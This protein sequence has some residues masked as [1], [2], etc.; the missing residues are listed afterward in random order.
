ME[1]LVNVRSDRAIKRALATG[2]LGM[3][4]QDFQSWQDKPEKWDAGWDF[5]ESI[6]KYGGKR[7]LCGPTRIVQ[8][9]AGHTLESQAS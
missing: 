2:L 3:T 5:F 1:G 6:M 4:S 7:H 9:N 8:E